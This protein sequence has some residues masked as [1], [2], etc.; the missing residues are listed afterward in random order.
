L[1]YSLLRKHGMINYPQLS[2]SM[3]VKG[4]Q[5]RKLISPTFKRRDAHGATDVVA[6][7][8]EAELRVNMNKRL[9]L[10]HMRFGVASSDDGSRAYFEDRIWEVA[11]PED[12]K[13]EN[14]KRPRAMPWVELTERRQKALGDVADMVSRLEVVEKQIHD[15]PGKAP[16]DL[17]TH[18]K[19]LQNQVRFFENHAREF[20]VEMLMRPALAMGCFFFILVA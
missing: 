17:L 15:Y 19:N 16:D 12:W 13:A 11:L 18:R 10:I 20:K 5:G 3:F 1:L 4:V 9:V 2:Y 8:K 6:Q 7:A 14:N